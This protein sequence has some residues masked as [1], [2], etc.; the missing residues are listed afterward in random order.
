MGN[1]SGPNGSKRRFL[2]AA[3]S[4][5]GGIGSAAVAVPFI[6][7]MTPSARARAAGAPIEV[8]IAR[9]EPGMMVTV[10][11]R[12]QP[13][14]II[15]RTAEMLANITKQNE[16]VADPESTQPLQPSYVGKETRSIKPEYVVLVGICSHLGCSPSEKFKVGADSGLGEDWL[17]GFFCPCHGSKFDLSG[18]VL[19]GMPAPVNLKVPPYTYLSDTRILIGQDSK[20]A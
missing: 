11:W 1:P 4:V 16:R 17:G 3:T 19:K 5:V 14:W 13:V 8:D 20:G 10:E 15:H 2:V 9:L 7:S 18:R 6:V 12:G